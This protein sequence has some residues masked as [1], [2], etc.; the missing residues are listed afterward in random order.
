[1]RV[2]GR[3]AQQTVSV[4]VA[5][6]KLKRAVRSITGLGRIARSKEGMTE[7]DTLRLVHAFVIS[8]IT[9][10]PPFQATRRTEIDQVYK[11]IRIACKAALGIPECTR[12]SRMPPIPRAE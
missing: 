8:R 7:A 3:H 5:L 1:M 11:F 2:L 12:H 10:A 4:S 6:S 9:Y